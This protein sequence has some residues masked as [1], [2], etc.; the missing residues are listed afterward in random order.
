M[1]ATAIIGAAAL[2]MLAAGAAQAQTAPPPSRAVWGV[3][4]YGQPV[5]GRPYGYPPGYAGP[6]TPLSEIETQAYVR[7]GENADG[8]AHYGYGG[9]P[10]AWRYDGYGQGYGY[11]RY[12]EDYAYRDRDRGHRYG[13]QRRERVRQGYRDEW[14]YQ[15]DRPPTAR[16]YGR[17]GYRHRGDHYDGCGCPD[18]YL[19]DR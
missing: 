8:Y 1:R 16:G 5:Y 7:T 15:D 4:A 2:L 6:G 18:V 3:A 13:G 10:S 11:S 9:Y 19:Y 17:D 12:R 14:G